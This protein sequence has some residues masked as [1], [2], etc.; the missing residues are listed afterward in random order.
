MPRQSIPM[1]P[2]KLTVDVPFRTGS[3]DACVRLA[4]AMRAILTGPD[5]GLIRS[6]GYDVSAGHVTVVLHVE[7]RADL[8]ADFIAAEK[9]VLDCARPFDGIERASDDVATDAPAASA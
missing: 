4:D 3:A 6:I 1:H 5:G 8:A 7:A 9:R 2:V